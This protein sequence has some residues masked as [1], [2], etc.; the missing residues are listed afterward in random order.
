MAIA[1]QTRKLAAVAIAA[2]ALA[3]AFAAGPGA[4]RADAAGP[5]VRWGNKLPAKLTHP[6][7]RK[8]ILCLLNKERTERGLKALDRDRD[9]QKAAQKHSKYMRRHGC[10]DHECPGEKTLVDRLGHV[11]Y[12]LNDLLQW[13]YGENIA[14]GEESLGTPK[15]MVKAWMHSEGHRANILN[16]S[17]RDIGIG[18]V[19]GS[20][21]DKHSKGGIYTTDFGLAID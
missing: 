5:C 16:G 18:F 13:A 9:L 7:A 17:F 11:G 2:V 3:L 15:A 21:N 14:W 12:L 4:S 19:K 6:Q 10:F 1:L 20:P 8:T